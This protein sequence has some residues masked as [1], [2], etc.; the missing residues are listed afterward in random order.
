MTRSILSGLLLLLMFQTLYAQTKP[1][2]KIT[3]RITDDKKAPLAFANV[4]VRQAKD[5][6]LVKGE[7]SDEQ[8]NATMDNI[9]AGHYFIQVT[10]M[11]YT[12]SQTAPFT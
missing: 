12:P 5:T 7:L 6:S 8:G 10:L 4:L 11:G 2:G 3:I 1:Q 9:P